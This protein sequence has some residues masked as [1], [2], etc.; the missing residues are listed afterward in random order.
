MYFLTIIDEYFAPIKLQKSIEKK[1]L[2]DHKVAILKLVEKEKI[3][4]IENTIVTYNKKLAKFNKTM[5]LNITI[6]PKK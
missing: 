3:K 4:K 6:S 2:Q 5:S 1:K